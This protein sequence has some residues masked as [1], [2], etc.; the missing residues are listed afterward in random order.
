MATSPNL[1]VGFVGLGSMGLRMARNLVRAGYMVKGY[2]INPQSVEAFAQAG[3][4]AAGTVADA[5][6]D[7]DV[8]LLVV[9]NARQ[10]EDVL[11]GAGEA[12]QHLRPGSVVAVHSTVEPDYVRGLAPRLYDA[13][14]ELV[15][16]PISGGVPGAEG[17]TL[18]IMASGHPAAF[19]RVRPLFDVM[20]KNVFVMGEEC[21]LGATM[22]VVNQ[23]LCG[24][25]IAAAAEAIA[26]A[27]QAGID[28]QNVFD[29]ISTS[30]ANSWMFQ[31]RVPRM[32]SGD[33]TTTSAVDIFVKD[34]GIVLDTGQASHFPLPLAAA[35]HQLFIMA[36]AA[37]HGLEHDSA[38]VK[39]YEQLTGVDVKS[40]S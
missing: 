33:Y 10:V 34:L 31:D 35:A 5:A 1:T 37:G 32:I 27:A 2:D 8:L 24:V 21:G 17:G 7:V 29:V 3:G 4:I 11:Y 23:L 18:A 15:D 28:S 30:A 22:K 6:Q 36:S 25:H 26:L 38:V 19:D 16:A 40:K 12:V 13:G 39:V 9:V 20:G 14:L